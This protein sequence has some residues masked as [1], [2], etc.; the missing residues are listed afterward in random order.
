MLLS[1]VNAICDHERSTGTIYS[2][3]SDKMAEKTDESD[4]T[5][6]KTTIKDR[7]PYF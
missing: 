5:L 2:E 4:E 6:L 7:V 1:L 3:V